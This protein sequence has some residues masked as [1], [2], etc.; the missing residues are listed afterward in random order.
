MS[1][2]SLTDI[3]EVLRARFPALGA[4]LQEATAVVRWDE[5]V[6]P[7][8]ARHARTLRVQDGVLWVEVDHP[9]WKS[10]LH[11]RRRQILEKLNA[12]LEPGEPQLTDLHLVEPRAERSSAAPARRV[13][14][15]PNHRHRDSGDR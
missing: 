3:L 1:L 7:A 13:S 5:A 6:G 10:E 12:H 14:K 15:K 9:A 2:R 4:R 11:H 8:I